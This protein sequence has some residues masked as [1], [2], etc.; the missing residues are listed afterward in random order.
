[1]ITEITDYVL[2]VPLQLARKLV[3]KMDLRIVDPPESFPDYRLNLIWHPIYEN[4][5]AQVWFREKLLDLPNQK[6]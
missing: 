5:P 2:T 6:L 4:D 1:M 3:K